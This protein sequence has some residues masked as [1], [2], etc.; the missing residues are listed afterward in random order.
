MALTA[1]EILTGVGKLYVAPAGTAKPSLD[2]DPAAAG[3]TEVGETVDGVTITLAQEIEEFR[4]DQRTGPVKATRT[5]ENLTIETRLAQATLENLAQTLGGLT[6]TTVPAGTGTM[7][8]KWHGLYRGQDV[9]EFAILFRG[10]SPYGDFPAQFYVPRGY[11]AG[12]TG[13]EYKKDGQ[14]VI[15]VEFHALEDLNA[16]SEAERFG[17]YEAGNAAAL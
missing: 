10:N 16:A 6:V 8:Y 2:T 11:F 1:Y 4:T 15:P 9:Q 13:L 3:W 12:E 17:V 5:E 7:G 14:V